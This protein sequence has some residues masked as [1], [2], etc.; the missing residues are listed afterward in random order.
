[1]EEESESGR[2]GGGCQT[3]NASHRASIFD[4]QIMGTGARRRSARIGFASA[5]GD[6][7]HR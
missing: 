7:L 3:S 4:K 2:R 5:H 1:M 6:T